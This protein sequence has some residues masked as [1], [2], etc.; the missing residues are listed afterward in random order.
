M[1]YFG[2]KR[3]MKKMKNNLD[4][5][6]ELILLQIEHNGCWISFWGLVIAMIVQLFLHDFD[7]RSVAGEWVVFMILALYIAIACMKNGIWDR[8]LKPNVKTNGI[9]SVIAGAVTGLFTFF[10]VIKRYPDKIAG[11]AASGVFVAIMIFVLCFI[12]LS[13]SSKAFKKR[14]EDQER[15]PEE[16]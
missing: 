2:R 4:E 11:S 12:A 13:L 5:R 7:I 15:E 1:I 6:Q 16:S 8:H 9:T 14:Q 10:V 3:I